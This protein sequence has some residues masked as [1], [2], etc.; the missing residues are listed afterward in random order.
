MDGKLLT[1]Q[2]NG[3]YLQVSGEKTVFIEVIDEA[4]NISSSKYSLTISE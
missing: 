1:R 2:K 4:K 3:H